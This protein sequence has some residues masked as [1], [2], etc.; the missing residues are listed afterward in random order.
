MPPMVDLCC[1]HVAKWF[2]FLLRIQRCGWPPQC[3]LYTYIVSSVNK[4]WERPEALL[5]IPWS[6]ESTSQYRGLITWSLG[7]LNLLGRYPVSVSGLLYIHTCHP[8]NAKWK[9]QYSIKC[10]FLLGILLYWKRHPLP[11]HIWT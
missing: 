1:G 8:Q 10:I 5:L 2:S 4:R 3:Q 11:P 7:F 9:V 6:L